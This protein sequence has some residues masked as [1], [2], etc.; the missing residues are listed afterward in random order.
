MESFYATNSFRAVPASY[1]LSTLESDDASEFSQQSLSSRYDSGICSLT[2]SGFRSG[3]CSIGGPSKMLDGTAGLEEQLRK[4]GIGEHEASS[5]FGV[6]CTSQYPSQFYPV[7]TREPEFQA[8][9]RTPMV[10][11]RNHVDKTSTSEDLFQ[12]DEDGD[13]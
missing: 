5:T 13:T 9:E 1:A 10:F 7:E 11:P 8:E 6:D 4:L 2:E 12:Q 3:L